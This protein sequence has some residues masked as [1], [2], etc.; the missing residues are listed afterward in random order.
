[1]KAAHSF[2]TFS[3][4]PMATQKSSTPLQTS[5]QMTDIFPFNQGIGVTPPSNIQPLNLAPKPPAPMD[6]PSAQPIPANSP[7]QS[8]I[9]MPG[10]DSLPDDFNTLKQQLGL[11]QPEKPGILKSI[12]K[13]LLD[14]VLQPARGIEQ[15]GKFIGTL[16]LSPEQRKKV[17][18]FMGPGLQETISGSKE[19]ATPTPT[20]GKQ[21]AGVALKTA[22]NLSVPFGTSLPSM[23][24]QGAAY[25]AG[26][27]LEKDRP[28]GE[29]AFDTALGGAGA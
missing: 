5:V 10:Q 8:S 20:S 4:N 13:G 3:H 25:G 7:L 9:P 6:L 18:D 23:A 15:L 21:A 27:A 1:M 19:Y 17:D 26:D 14:I 29:V 12:G 28:M 22:A 2:E 11:S 16:G 24:L